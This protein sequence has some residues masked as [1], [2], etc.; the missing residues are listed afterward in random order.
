[1]WSR[2]RMCG[3]SVPVLYLGCGR[4]WRGRRAGLRGCGR[5]S[6]SWCGALPAF[7]RAK[8]ERIAGLT[9]S[10][11]ASGVSS[12][13]SSDVRALFEFVGDVV[14]EHAEEHACAD[15]VLEVVVDRA[16]LDRVLHRSERVLGELELLVGADRGGRAEPLGWDGGADHVETIER[17]L[18][19]DLLGV[20]VM[21]RSGPS[22]MF[23]VKCLA[24]LYLLTTTPS[25]LADLVPAPAA[26]R[27]SAG[28]GGPI[29]LTLS[30]STSVAAK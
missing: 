15:A 1:M 2:A 30:S 23:S 21:G 20:A 29:A 19:G 14:G 22:A 10:I 11:G 16:D 18:A 12:V 8:G 24:T 5:G 25:A 6:P 3:R 13:N 7:A 27:G 9:G 28:S 17:G 4:S 26:R